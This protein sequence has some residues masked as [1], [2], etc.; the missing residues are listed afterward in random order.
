MVL[1]IVKSLCLYI[2]YPSIIFNIISSLLCQCSFCHVELLFSTYRLFSLPYTSCWS[3]ASLEE[4]VLVSIMQLWCVYDY[5]FSNYWS[6]VLFHLF[7][8]FISWSAA[9][10]LVGTWQIKLKSV[11]CNLHQYCLNTCADT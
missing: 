9:F 6:L 8:Y 7:Y 4:L 2:L 5:K 11:W 1:L 3:S 10:H